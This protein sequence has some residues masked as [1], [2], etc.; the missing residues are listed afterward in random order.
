MIDLVSD[1]LGGVRP[2]ARKRAGHGLV[3]QR[4]AVDQRAV[5]IEEDE[6]HQSSP[7]LSR[8]KPNR[9]QLCCICGG[10]GA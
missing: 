5:A 7:A 6:M 3:D 10:R 9:F 8:S 4:R 1:R 2:K